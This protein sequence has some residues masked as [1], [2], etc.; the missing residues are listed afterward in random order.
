MVG[1]SPQPQYQ[2]FKEQLQY[3]TADIAKTL[4]AVGFETLEA[5]T[6]YPRLQ[7]RRY[8]TG[9]AERDIWVSFLVRFWTGIKEAA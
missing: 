1:A 5:A 2:G 7:Y 6:V 8:W 4:R 3:Y 9:A